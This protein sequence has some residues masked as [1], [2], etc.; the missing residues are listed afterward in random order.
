MSSTSTAVARESLPNSTT[1]KLGASKTFTGVSDSVGGFTKVGVAVMAN[2]EIE[3]TIYQGGTGVFWDKV[4]TYTIP[5]TAAPE[6]RTA[7][8]CPRVETALTQ[9]FFYITAR[10]TSVVDA[11]YT[12]IHSQVFNDGYLDSSN[13]NV[14]M[15]GTDALD[16]KHKILT[17]ENGRLIVNINGGGG[18]NTDF[19]FYPDASNSTVAI[20]ADGQQP[21]Q[22]T[23]A[24]WVYTNNG[25][26]PNKIN[27][28]VFQDVTLPQYLVSEMESIYFVI[29]QLPTATT[30]PFVVFYTMPNGIDD[31]VPSFAKSRLTFA[32]NNTVPTTQGEYLFYVSGDPT[33]IRPEITNRY[34]LSFVA[35]QSS[36]TLAQAAGERLSLATLST[37]STDPAGSNYFLFQQYG[38]QWAKTSVYLPVNN[39][40]LETT[41]TNSGAI[42][43]TLTSL[44][45]KVTA[46]DTG[47]ISG[48]VS[49]T[50]TVEETNSTS[51]YNTLVTLNGKVVNCDTGFVGLQPSYGIISFDATNTIVKRAVSV[52][53][54]NLLSLNYY[55]DAGSVNFVLVYNLGIA[56]VTVGTTAPIAVFALGK[57]HGDTIDLHR[58]LVGT[59]ITLAVSGSYDGTSLPHGSGAYLTVSFLNA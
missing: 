32:P 23:A 43:T 7:F 27:W 15:Y 40:K 37:G 13:D 2:V 55:N 20:Y 17:D 35:D 36:K 34:Q 21:T 39:G 19:A 29:T 22:T 59:A 6:P 46:C 56:S 50:G 52:V 30:L 33:T 31:L 57:N 48:S 28:Y 12:R 18:A 38:I 16:A 47:A 4:T 53:A 10:N 11:S 9:R 51:I 3:L 14:L 42:S 49:I 58:L 5:A 44:N 8:E 24:G 26:A 45:G 1:I 25:T 41:E 54:N